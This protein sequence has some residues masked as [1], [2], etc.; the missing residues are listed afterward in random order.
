MYAESQKCNAANWAYADGIEP[1]TSTAVL[2]WSDTLPS[3]VITTT[4]RNHTV[5]CIGTAHGQMVKVGDCIN[6]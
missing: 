5:A 3:S 6:H 4:H 1:L 2:E